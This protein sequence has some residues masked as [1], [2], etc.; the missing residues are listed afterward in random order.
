MEQNSLLW[1]NTPVQLGAQS[2]EQPPSVS[3]VKTPFTQLLVHGSTIS[4]A[5]SIHGRINEV[6]MD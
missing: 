4:P 3:L 6:L 2:Q 5:K 1:H